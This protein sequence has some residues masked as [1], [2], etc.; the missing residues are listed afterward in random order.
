MLAVLAM[1][2]SITTA[3]CVLAWTAYCTDMSE[4]N[5]AGSKCIEA[6][7]QLISDI[8][9]A[10]LVAARNS[11]ELPPSVVTDPSVKLGPS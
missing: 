2:L 7:G 6:T 11:F 10:P 4:F 8:Y 1:G 3:L 5:D 9:K